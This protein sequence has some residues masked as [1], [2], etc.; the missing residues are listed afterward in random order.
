M[1]TISNKSYENLTAEQRVRA[2]VAAVARGDESEVKRLRE[3]CPKRT[4]RMNDAAFSDRLERLWSLSLAMECDLRGLTIRVLQGSSKALEIGDDN[5]E[6]LDKV[7]SE[8]DEIII[9]IASIDEAW[10]QTLEGLGIDLEDMNKAGMAHASVTESLLTHA[11]QHYPP[12]SETVEEFR[13]A[14]EKN[15]GLES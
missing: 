8:T 1:K 15:L 2:A 6:E 9:E 12:N 3:T 11:R 4:Y 5:A 7:I 14:M 13:C 10:R